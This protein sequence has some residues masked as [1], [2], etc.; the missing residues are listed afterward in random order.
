MSVCK[1]FKRLAIY[2]FSPLIEC[3][4]SCFFIWFQPVFYSHCKSARVLLHPDH[5]KSISI[6]LSNNNNSSKLKGKRSMYSLTRHVSTFQLQLH[7]YSLQQHRFCS[8]FIPFCPA[9]NLYLSLCFFT[10]VFDG[11]LFTYLNVVLFF[12]WFS[13]IQTNFFSFFKY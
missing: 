13:H 5:A 12:C 1:I 3:V 7:T 9:F 4:P 2:A 10:P 8:I 11:Q 6:Q